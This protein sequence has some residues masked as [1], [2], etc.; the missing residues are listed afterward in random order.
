VRANAFVVYLLLPH[1]VLLARSAD[2]WPPHGEKLVAQAMEYGISVQSLIWHASNILELG[3]AE[4][5]D[6]S[7]AS[8]RPYQIARRIGL[9]DRVTQEMAAKGAKGWPRRYL[10]LVVR[11]LEHGD[12]PR[13]ELNA[14]LE[15]PSLVADIL[16]P[17]DEGVEAEEPAG[18]PPAGR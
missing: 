11:A 8:Q 3:D 18:F 12:I 17:A 4:R 1:E 16:R 10:S 7:L 2:I 6:L 9:H 13:E 15:D 5:R 14:W